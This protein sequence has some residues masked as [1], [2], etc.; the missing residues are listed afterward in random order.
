MTGQAG[1][2]RETPATLIVILAVMT[3]A[4]AFLA[5]RVDRVE[6][7]MRPAAFQSV[8]QPGA[9]I[10][11]MR[12]VDISGNPLRIDMKGRKV[13]LVYSENCQYSQ[14]M[15]PI[16][17]ELAATMGESR[18]VYVSTDDFRKLKTFVETQSLR[19]PAVALAGD[20]PLREKF[21]RVPQTLFV[22]DGRVEAVEVGFRPVD[23]L[24]RV[25]AQFQN[26][27]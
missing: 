23:R 13:V 19:S 1:A 3:A 22:A 16:W 20:N 25:A 6:R 24:L 17:R 9:D 12:V 18:I 5:V 14:R 15:F 26:K 4:I 27:N 2:M 11:A 7:R 8:V 10:S 21:T